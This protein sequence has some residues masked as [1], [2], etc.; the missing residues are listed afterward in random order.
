MK[1]VLS[2]GSGAGATNEPSATWSLPW[3]TRLKNLA[4]AARL[5]SAE[6]ARGLKVARLQ[7]MANPAASWLR[8]ARSRAMPATLSFLY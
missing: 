2:P 7:S 6:N 1:R 3:H 4:E 8:R 5:E